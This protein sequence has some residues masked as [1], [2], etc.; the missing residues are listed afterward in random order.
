[1]GGVA[2]QDR[3]TGEAVFGLVVPLP[4][5][6]FKVDPEGLAVFLRGLQFEGLVGER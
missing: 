2:G 4:R 6:A 3:R 5:Q 1:M